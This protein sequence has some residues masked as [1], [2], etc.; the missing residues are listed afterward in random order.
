MPRRRG[1]SISYARADVYGGKIAKA[2]D[3]R[4]IGGRKLFEGIA[5]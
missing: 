2:E 5:Y 3:G 4:Y 1:D